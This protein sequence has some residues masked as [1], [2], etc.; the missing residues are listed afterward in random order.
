MRGCP[1]AKARHPPKPGVHRPIVELL[2]RAA[3]EAELAAETA[4]VVVDM[5]DAHWCTHAARQV[6]YLA[7]LINE[8]ATNARNAGATIIWAP[9]TVA[10]LFYG[11]RGHP[12]RRRTLGLAPAKP[13]KRNLTEATPAEKLHSSSVLNPAQHMPPHPLLNGGCASNETK[14][15]QEPYER[16]IETL[17]IE[18]GMSLP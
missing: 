10:R 2:L 7:P 13:L 12:A 3:S 4:I 18:Y 14:P 8:F 17:H 6:A 11:V 1:P 5:W 16:Q 15:Y 9:A